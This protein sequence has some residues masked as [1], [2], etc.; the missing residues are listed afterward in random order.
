MNPSKESSARVSEGGSK[1]H[2]ALKQKKKEMRR[3][4]YLS[5]EGDEMRV[6]IRR[7]ISNDPLSEVSASHLLEDHPH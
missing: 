6:Y 1:R 7:V 3:L 4:V 2:D 5:A